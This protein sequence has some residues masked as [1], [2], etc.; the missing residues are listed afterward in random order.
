MRI[1]PG[2]NKKGGFVQGRALTRE[3]FE[4]IQTEKAIF[5]SFVKGVGDCKLSANIK[6]LKFCL[7]KG[8]KLRTRLSKSAWFRMDV[9]F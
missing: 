4:D 6:W 5:G 2:R 1:A 9:R 3:V 8:S 7:I